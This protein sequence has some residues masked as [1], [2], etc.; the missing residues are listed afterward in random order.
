MNSKRHDWSV[1]HENF[2]VGPKNVLMNVE[3]K[4]FVPHVAFGLKVPPVTVPA[5]KPRTLPVMSGVTRR[6]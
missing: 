3:R 5:M 4:Q 2:A 1:S 6:P